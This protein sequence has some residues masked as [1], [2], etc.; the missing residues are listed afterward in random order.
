[1][2]RKETLKTHGIVIFILLILQY[3]L[4]MF[5]NLFIQFPQDKHDGQ[6]WE[7][8][9]KQIPI[10]AHIIIGIL[11]L[12][13]ALVLVVRSIRQKNKQ[14][15]IISSI[16][17][18][19]ILIAGVSGAIFIPTQTATY[20]FVMSLSFIIAFVSYSLGIYRSKS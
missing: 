1:M 15:I 11:L 17:A 6:L 9:W 13:G 4:G 8:A 20:S 19:S 3:L 18:I 10:A 5:T 16:G 2:D 14:W 7:F 12:I